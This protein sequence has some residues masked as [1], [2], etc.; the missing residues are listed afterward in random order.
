MSWRLMTTRGT[1]LPPPPIEWLEY[2]LSELKPICEID[3]FAEFCDRGESCGRIFGTSLPHIYRKTF[4]LDSI[5]VHFAN[6]L[7]QIYYV[8]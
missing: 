7:N 8:S 2:G 5:V 4:T 3:E 6:Q 1:P